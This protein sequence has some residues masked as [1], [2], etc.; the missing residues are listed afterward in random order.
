MLFLH[1][2][3]LLAAR[4][5]APLAVAEAQTPTRPQE[6][7]DTSKLWTVHL[8]FTA[9][10]WQAMEPKGGPSTGN[11]PFGPGGFGV[12]GG[13]PGE[14]LSSAF[15]KGDANHDG[16][17]SSQE[18]RSL[19]LEWFNRWDTGK[20]GKVTVEQVR[21]GL[22]TTIGGPELQEPVLR[23]PAGD[24]PIQARNGRNELPAMDDTDFEYVHASFELGG[25]TRTEVAIRYKG[26]STFMSSRNS[27]K[28]SMKLDLNKYD[29]G[30]ALAGLTKLNL[31]SNV[32][33]AARM[34]EALG[35]RLFR[36]AGIP[37][38]RT[39]YARVYLTVTGKYNRHYLGLYSIVEEV[40]GHFARD[41]FG[42]VNGA[43]FKPS[44]HDLF[45][46]LGDDWSKY[47]AVYDPKTEL[48]GQQQ[49]RLIEFA[50]L[51]T[52][53]SDAEFAERLGQF[54]DLDEFARYFA[55]NVWLAN[56]DSI[57]SMGHNFYLYLDPAN[58]RFQI[59]PWDLDLAFGGMGGGTDLSIEHPWRGKN[60][61][62]E[63]LFG[64][65]AF[66]KA[67]RG[68][69]AKLNESIFRPDRLVKL[70]DDTAAVIRPAVKEESEAQL[71][72]F[73]QSVAG[74]VPAQTSDGGGP[75]APS[76]APIKSFAAQRVESVTAQ[77][78]GKS[79]GKTTGG[80]GLPGLNGG[81]DGGLRGGPGGGPAELLASALAQ[82]LDE[83][84]DGSIS[85]E[86]FERGWAEMFQQWGGRE[87]SA[88][89]EEQIRAGINRNFGP[90]PGMVPEFG[91]LP[92]E[93]RQ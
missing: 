54:I 63:R 69:L 64:V 22:G 30:R 58:N 24:G 23:G 38:P 8:K 82:K 31:H 25:L 7:F 5:T 6:L 91:P 76:G 47:K 41:R 11:V 17:L 55:V 61:F 68:H 51:T 37:A 32:T 67:Y 36:D 39:G 89:S 12:P 71:A 60:R 15:L 2:I 45:A 73:D 21:A 72:R 62:V 18:F 57:L 9:A 27:L 42:T 66:L 78:M 1:L 70:V 20:T 14:F 3:C 10:Q 88:L 53:A 93:P 16:K 59:L 48:S 40:D 86:E 29:E 35:Y 13:G 56:M 52:H 74:Q 75:A 84:K 79:T 33:D 46:D 43:I 85:R 19:G 4:L 65:E 83:N 26:N 49:R 81:P 34:N 50:R 90:S 28:R 77:L 44:T 80:F 87:N 92:Q